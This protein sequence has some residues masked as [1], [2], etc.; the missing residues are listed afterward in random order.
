MV[1]EATNKKFTSLAE[2]GAKDGVVQ[3]G[4]SRPQLLCVV[5]V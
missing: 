5:G 4:R 3:C 1:V 2:E